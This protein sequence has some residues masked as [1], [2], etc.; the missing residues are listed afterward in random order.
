[1]SR[2]EG[3]CFPNWAPVSAIEIWEHWDRDHAWAFKQMPQ[4]IRE[5]YIKRGNLEAVERAA[6]KYRSAKDAL[7][8]VLTDLRMEEVWLMVGAWDAEGI[9]GSKIHDSVFASE[10][11]DSTFAE[12]IMSGCLGPRGKTEKMTRQE[13][14]QWRN[15]VIETAERLSSLIRGT[16]LA[17]IITDDFNS[18][19]IEQRAEKN[20]EPGDMCFYLRRMQSAVSNADFKLPFGRQVVPKVQLARPNDAQADRKFFVLSLYNDLSGFMEKKALKQLLLITTIVVYELDEHSFEMRQ[21][22][23]YLK[24]DR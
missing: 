2:E 12:V 4:H 22:D 1:M 10:I 20:V 17:S 21:I 11:R 13:F 24:K 16:D 6:S 5:R 8:R 19:R 23:R 9:A 15:G 7:F 18:L 14:E 3:A